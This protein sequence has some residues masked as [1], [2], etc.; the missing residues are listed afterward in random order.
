MEMIIALVKG[1]ADIQK[2]DITGVT[3]LHVASMK[4]NPALVD[5]LIKSVKVN[6]GALTSMCHLSRIQK[7]QRS[8]K[9][10]LLMKSQNNCL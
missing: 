8:K 3:P 9:E 6:M 4:L 5:F 7:K 10:D 1:E 2:Q